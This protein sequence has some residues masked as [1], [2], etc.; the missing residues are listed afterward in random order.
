MT[1]A[2]DSVRAIFFTQAARHQHEVTPFFAHAQSS[3]P[4]QY[5]TPVQQSSPVVQSSLHSTPRSS[6]SRERRLPPPPPPP[7]DDLPRTSMEIYIL[8]VFVVQRKHH[9]VGSSRKLVP[10]S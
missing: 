10:I 9:V 5:S 6:Y 3:T 8:I 1:I 7:P 2:V 4:L